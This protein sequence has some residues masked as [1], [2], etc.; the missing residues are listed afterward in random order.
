LSPT[1]S[2]S[3]AHGAIAATTNTSTG[4]SGTTNTAVRM[5]RISASGWTSSRSSPA[6]S[7]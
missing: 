7:A 5:Y 3:P 6:D 1:S 4:T 2:A